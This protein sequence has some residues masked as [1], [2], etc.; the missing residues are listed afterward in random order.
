MTEDATRAQAREADDD[1]DLTRSI[2]ALSMPVASGA[3]DASSS[4]DVSSSALLVC[5]DNN[6]QK[7]GEKWLR[8]FGFDTKLTTDPTEALSVARELKPD[9]IVVEAW[10]CDGDGVK[11][12]E[13][14]QDAA[15]LNV[16]LIVLCSQS[17]EVQAAINADAFDV[18][19]KPVEWQIVAQ[20]AKIAARL[21]RTEEQLLAEQLARMEALH[22][23]N[24]AHKKLR[25]S[26]SF[27]PV[28]GLPNKTKF[29]DLVQRGMRAAERDRNALAVLVIGFSRFRLVIEAL[30]Q[31]GADMVV[32]EIATRMR[33]CL[34][35]VNADQ[36]QMSGL[37]T[38]AAANLDSLRFGLMFTCSKDCTELASR[39]QRLAGELS[40]PVQVAG[41]IV[42]LSACIGGALYPQD[43]DAA[44]ILLQRADNAMREAHNSAASFRLYCREADAAATRKLDIENM[45][46]EAFDQNKFKLAY[47]PILDVGS[48]RVIGAEAL[49]RWPQADGS[50]I[51]PEEFVPVAEDC[52]LMIQLGAWVL[53]ESC[54]QLQMWQQEGLPPL[55]MSVNV[56]RCQL[57]AGGFVDSVQRALKTYDLDPACLDL[58]LSERGVLVGLDEAISQ[59]HMLKSINVQICID[60]FGTGE[61]A[62]GYLKELP[63]DVLKI[64][65]SYI[66]GLNGAGKETAITSAM[67]A[68]GQS[69]DLTVIAEGVETPEQLAILRDLACDE[70]QGLYQS[71]AIS[72]EA[73]ADFVRKMKA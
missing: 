50:F 24:H 1:L 7:W 4:D 68:L 48:G 3:N 30:G 44:D 10:L 15:D 35:N 21:K 29:L 54:R 51:G 36:E 13:S 16:P 40:R 59:L 53:D 25:S 55:R 73:F 20:R 47:Q 23:A 28:T 71:P 72:S 6:A 32:A 22:L 42:H 57:M 70:Y 69:L 56:S 52:G 26:E 33:T 64:D 67:V 46:Y 65:R 61:A 14:L 19:R 45:L 66:N 2:K 5:R 18:V 37:R 39:Q 43:A 41:Q 34:E 11:V 58:E 12:F 27:E 8:Q 62:I 31:E 60:D 38:A 9:V 17:R 63:I 49:L